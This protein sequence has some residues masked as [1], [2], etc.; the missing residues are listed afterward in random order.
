MPTLISAFSSALTAAHTG[1]TNLNSLATATTNLKNA[2]STLKDDVGTYQTVSYSNRSA[3]P[4]T[5]EAGKIYVATNTGKQYAWNGT[6]YEEV[7]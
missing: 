5:G 3:F 7:G 2:V 1:T 4:A 6:T